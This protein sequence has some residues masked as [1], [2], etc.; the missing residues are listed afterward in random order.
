VGI[1]APAGA[2]IELRAAD[3]RRPTIAPGAEVVIN[4]GQD[5]EV[6]INGIL[7]TGARIRVP[8]TTKRAT[9][10]LRHCTVVPGIARN[11][12]GTATQPTA[13]SLLIESD[14]VTVEIEHSVVGGVRAHEDVVV[15][16][17]S[18]IVDAN[19]PS[20]VAYAALDGAGAGGEL[21]LVT[22]TVIGKVHARVLRLVSNTVLHARL[23]A[24][25][26]WP[27]PVHADTAASRPARTTR[28]A[29]NRSS[30]PSNTDHPRI[31]S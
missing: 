20:H 23:A 4:M 15:H 6:T 26:P 8:A 29:C 9:L 3:G 31:A 21:Q 25:D 28:C 13:A 7:L 18:S 5:A 1:D 16:I 10:R 12:D 14:S 19:D 30:P 2:R 24:A 17:T 11:V 27:F 22:S